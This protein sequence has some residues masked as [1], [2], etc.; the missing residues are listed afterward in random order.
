MLHAIAELSQHRVGDVGGV[1]CYEVDT[2]TL[3]AD[4]SHH[5]FNLVHQALRRIGE[6]CVSL[7][8]EEHQS[9]QF[10]VAHLGQTSVEVGEEPKQEGGVELGVEHQLVSCQDV[11][12][13]SPVGSALHQVHDVEGR[14]AE[15]LFSPLVLVG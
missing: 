2:Y 12:D 13:A 15:E 6:E 3:A 14:F 9:W 4:E 1:L 11:H 8:E 10:L 7:V 5:L